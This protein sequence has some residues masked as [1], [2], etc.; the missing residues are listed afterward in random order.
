MSKIHLITPK[1]NVCHFF[2][3]KVYDLTMNDVHKVADVAFEQF[4]FIFK[5]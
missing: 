3:R 1:Q 5:I 2:A 4:L